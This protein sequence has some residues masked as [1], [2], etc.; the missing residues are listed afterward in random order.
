MLPIRPPRVLILAVHH[1]H[2][3]GHCL[4]G[5]A[6][7][8]IR[9]TVRRLLAAGARVHVAYSG[10]SIY[11][12]IAR[13]VDDPRRLILER[14]NWLD[15]NLSG[16]RRLNPR[17]VLSRARWFRNRDPDV[18]FV[19]QQGHG[20]AFGAS[21]VGAALAGYPVVMSIRQPAWHGPPARE[22]ETGMPGACND[23][24]LSP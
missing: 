22:L 14:T 2:H 15:A 12:D 19:V 23:S 20:T 3:N 4:L 8:Y 6:E 7:K 13:E 1:V 21:I 11:D 18:V 24:A 17:L 16:D 5:G 10:D 9:D